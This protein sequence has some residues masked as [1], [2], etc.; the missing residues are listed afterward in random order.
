MTFSRRDLIAIAVV[1]AGI[2]GVTALVLAR[3]LRFADVDTYHADALAFVGARRLPPEYP[4]L[5]LLPFSLTI[6][7]GVAYAWAFSLAMAA[8]FLAGWIGVARLAGRRAG[9][10][11]V[12]YVLVGGFGVFL[13]RYDLVPALVTVAAVAAA[14]KRRWSLAY[15]LLGLGVL[16]KLYPAVLLPLFVIQQVRTDRSETP[17]LAWFAAIVAAGNVISAALAGPKWLDPYRFALD[18]PVQVESVP[19]TV[20]WIASLLGH[21]ANFDHTFNSFNLTGSL[22]PPVTAVCS[23]IFLGGS[24]FIYYRH[25]R[26][27]LPLRRAALAMVCLLLVTTKVFSTQYLIWVVPLVAIELGLDP[28][29]IL[30]CVL[31]TLIFPTLYFLT[32]LIDQPP[33]LTT[34]EYSWPFL[35]AI[36]TRN[37][38]LVAATL[39]VLSRTKFETWMRL[40]ARP[41]SV[42]S[43]A[44]ETH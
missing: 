17:K 16:L 36:A 18:R 41:R 31:T 20:L 38:L 33:E 1:M 39:L 21:P 35:A 22:A 27:Q 8:V 42:Q 32:G 5:A 13:A 37:A 2:V 10:A 30:I 6:V 34:H 23:A 28:V 9:I 4:I 3:G 29:W 40:T 15:V 7:P 12:V 26:N 14:E 11:Y 25:A 43:A 44:H 24:L 19:G